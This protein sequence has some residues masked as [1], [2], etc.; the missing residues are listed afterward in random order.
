[1]RFQKFQ[2]KT[3]Q[4]KSQKRNKK[5]LK[6]ISQTQFQRH[7]VNFKNISKKINNKK[8]SKTLKIR[9][10]KIKNKHFNKISKTNNIFKILNLDNFKKIERKFKKKFKE[11]FT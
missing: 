5:Y 9:T 2:Q 3:L 4:Q 6:T 8:H 11:N 7:L 10:K 1:M